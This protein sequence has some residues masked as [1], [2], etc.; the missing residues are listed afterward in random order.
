MTWFGGKSERFKWIVKNLP[1]ARRKQWY[2]EPFAGMLGV[3][4]NRRKSGIESVNDL[5]DRVVNFWQVIR[6]NPD[7]LDSLLEATP[8]SRT[9]F[10][11]SFSTIDEG[12]PIERARKFVVTVS[13]GMMKTDNVKSDGEFFWFTRLASPTLMLR[14]G[15]IS[16]LADRLRYTQLENMDAVKMIE[17]IYDK[18]PNLSFGEVVLYLDPPYRTARTEI[19][20]ESV[21]FERLDAILPKAPDHVKIAVSGYGDDYDFLGWRAS[22]SLTYRRPETADRGSMRE[23]KSCG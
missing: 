9:E 15:R 3:L 18:V 6:E 17:R 7:E 1:A 12:S 21:D 16:R 22:R 2:V 19:Y 8:W 5:N 20:R 13:Q 4:L 23:R 14:G 11:N 10:A